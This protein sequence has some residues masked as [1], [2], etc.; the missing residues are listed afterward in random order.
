MLRKIT[1]AVGRFHVGNQLDYPRGVWVQIEKD[2]GMPLDKFSV[3][4]ESNAVLQSALKGRVRIHR[5]LGATA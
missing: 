4:I 1:Q 3:A 5:R 2:A